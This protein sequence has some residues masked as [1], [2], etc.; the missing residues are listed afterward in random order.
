MES[1]F[2]LKSPQQ[3]FEE[4]AGEEGPVPEAE[5]VSGGD[6]GE[7]LQSPSQNGNTEITQY[8]ILQPCLCDL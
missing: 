4:K 3:R 5:V 7:F 8:A 6:S 2:P 1:I